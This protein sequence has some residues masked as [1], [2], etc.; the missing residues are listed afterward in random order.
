MYFN[1]A[2]FTKM[3]HVF[4]EQLSRKSLDQ[5]HSYSSPQ[6]PSCIISVS[7][8][9]RSTELN[10]Q[11]HFA[12]SEESTFPTVMLSYR[13]KGWINIATCVYNSRSQINCFKM[14]WK[15]L[16]FSLKIKLMN[17]Y[18]ASISGGNKNLSVK[19]KA[20][21]ADIFLVHYFFG[22]SIPIIKITYN[23]TRRHWLHI[24]KIIKST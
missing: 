8:F 20:L 5:F 23:Q 17:T 1:C 3:L 22:I 4:K 18:K 9:H 21:D 13:K 19:V 6:M 10:I 12:E 11:D 24:L 14:K 16:Y 15:Q 7:N 2:L